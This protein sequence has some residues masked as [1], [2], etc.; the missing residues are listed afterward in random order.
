[1][2]GL[3]I[4]D[5]TYWRNSWSAE[6][7]QKLNILNST[8]NLFVFNNGTR[9]EDVLKVLTEVPTKAYNL[10]RIHYSKSGNCGIFTDSGQCYELDGID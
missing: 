5:P 10:I 2:Y 6:I 7:G 9:K 3:R 1:M 8:Y 4:I